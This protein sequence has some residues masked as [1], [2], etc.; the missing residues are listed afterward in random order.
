MPGVETKLGMTVRPLIVEAA[1]VYPVAWPKSNYVPAAE[2]Y[3]A[4]TRITA[5]PQRMTISAQHRRLM[6]VVLMLMVPMDDKR[7][8]EYWTE[9]AT[10]IAGYFPA[11]LRRTFDGLTVRVTQDPHVSDGFREGAWWQV[12]IRVRLETFT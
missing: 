3:L 6:S 12:P 10:V 4:V 9:Q 7:T 2:P 11:D 5:E 1:G 8:D